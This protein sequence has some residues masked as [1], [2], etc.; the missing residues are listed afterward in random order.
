MVKGISRRVI[1]V[2]AEKSALFEEAFFV[3]RDAAAPQRDAVREAC[4]VAE[5]YMNGRAGT[6]TRRRFT[7][8]QLALSASAGGALTSA[9]WAAGLW[10]L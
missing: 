2:R 3:V 9:A 4:T 1:V 10:L 5:R 7:G 8:A 6:H